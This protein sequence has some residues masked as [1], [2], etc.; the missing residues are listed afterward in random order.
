MQITARDYL[1]M[2]IAKATQS[3]NMTLASDDKFREFYMSMF[4]PQEMRPPQIEGMRQSLEKAM[5]PMNS[6]AKAFRN[7]TRRAR[8]FKSLHEL[9]KSNETSVRWMTMMTVA[10]LVV[11]LI[12]IVIASMPFF[13]I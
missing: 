10:M 3:L 6:I 7:N 9:R 5:V 11:G 4:M 1:E 13:K 2:E 12:Q 8:E